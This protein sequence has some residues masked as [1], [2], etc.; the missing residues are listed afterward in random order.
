VAVTLSICA[1]GFAFF[2]LIAGYFPIFEAHSPEAAPREVETKEA[3]PVVV[4]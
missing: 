4:G 2:R 1:A 3:D